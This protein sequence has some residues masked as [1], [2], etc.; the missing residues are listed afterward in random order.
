MIINTLTANYEFARNNNENLPRP[1]LMQLPEKPKA[2]QKYLIEVFES[3]SS[4][5]QLEKT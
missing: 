2:F 5:E 3:A 1:I 4:F